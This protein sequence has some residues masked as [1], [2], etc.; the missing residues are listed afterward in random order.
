MRSIRCLRSTW[1]T[2]IGTALATLLLV[3]ACATG[4]PNFEAGQKLLAEGRLEEALAMLKRAADEDPGNREY[5]AYYFRQRDSAVNQLLL[6]AE[7]ARLV[8]DFDAADVHYRRVRGI[9]PDNVRA[10]AG[11]ERTKLDRRHRALLAEAD[12][13]MKKRNLDAAAAKLQTIL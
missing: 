1:L 10:A 4:N 9:A 11:L 7:E 6:R 2:R 3:V 12:A 13:F 8:G 5:R